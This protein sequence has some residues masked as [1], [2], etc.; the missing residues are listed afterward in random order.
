M[1][2]HL[3]FLWS[4]LR[5]VFFSTGSMLCS[6]F[7]CFLHLF[8]FTTYKKIMINIASVL[9]CKSVLVLINMISIDAS[10]KLHKIP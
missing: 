6:D 5:N 4:C 1:I 7:P 9:Y 3:C 2:I 10:R 8:E